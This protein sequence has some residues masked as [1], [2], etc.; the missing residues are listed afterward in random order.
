MV[1]SLV[2]GLGVVTAAP[3][4]ATVSV[5]TSAQL[6]KAIAEARPGITIRITPGTYQGSIVA[7]GLRGQPERPIVLAAADPRHPPVIKGGK[8]GLYLAGPAY[9]E[10]HNLVVTGTQNNGINIDDVGTNG[11]PAHDIILRGLIVRDLGP[12]GNQHGIKLSGVDRLQIVNCNLERW[13]SEGSGIAM[14]GCHQGA[15]LGCLLRHTGRELGYGVQIKG[16]SSNI[17]VRRCRFEHTGSRAANLGGNTD[18]P[19]F[20]PRPQGYE[21]KDLIVEDCIFIGSGA[22]IALVGVDGAVVR[23]N[24][25]YRPRQWSLRI[26]QETNEPGFVPCRNGVVSDNII[27]FRSDEMKEPINIGN[28]TAPE[29]FRLSHNLWFCQDDPSRSR[30]MLPIPEVDGVY[31]QDPQ[32]LDP[33]RGNFRPSDDS[34]WKGLGPR[35]K[36]V[37]D[38]SKTADRPQN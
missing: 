26:L 6:R 15:I 35:I 14:V 7:G 12:R 34:P 30:P 21:A 38:S 37:T 24:T 31:G 18:L 36:P 4:R 32:L 10:L 25:F 20:R 9:V 29:T 16:G 28:A 8:D 33:E 23:H 17:L 22:P 27:I 3:E 11:T 2:I 13:G 5:A 19:Y 1:L